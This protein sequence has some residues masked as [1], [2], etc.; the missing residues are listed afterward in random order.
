MMQSWYAA[1]QGISYFLTTVGILKGEIGLPVLA[2]FKRAKSSRRFQKTM[3]ALH[4][5]TILTTTIN[6]KLQTRTMVKEEFTSPQASEKR[7]VTPS[8]R[9]RE[10][11]QQEELIDQPRRS[12]RRQKYSG[13]IPATPAPVSCQAFETRPEFPQRVDQ[14]GVANIPRS[15]YNLKEV[16]SNGL[17]QVVA[18]IPGRHTI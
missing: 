10:R 16:L 13:S 3:M 17:R 6:H 8:I 11:S 9:K 18:N 2:S 4:S 14:M 1:Q 15:K 7:R 12:K 5:P